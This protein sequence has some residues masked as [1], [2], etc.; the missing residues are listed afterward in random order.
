MLAWPIPQE[1]ATPREEIASTHLSLKVEIDQFHLDEE[2]EAPDRL[3]KVSDSK[4]GLDRSSVADFSRLVV[5]WI[6][7]SE[8]EEDMA[9]N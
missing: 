4:A 2:G 7:S 8:E 9:L 5:A 6:D 3:V 1:V